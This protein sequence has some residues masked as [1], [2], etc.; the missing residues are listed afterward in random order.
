MTAPLKPK[1]AVS[2]PRTAQAKST[3]RAV[4]KIPKAAKVVKAVNA[5]KATEATKAAKVPR[6]P[7]PRMTLPDEIQAEGA[8]GSI[9]DQVIAF[10]REQ[11][12][13]AA[14]DLFFE[15]G[16]QRTTLEAVAKKLHFTKPF[17][18]YHFKDKE[19]VLVEIS[20]RSIDK[21]N[22]ALAA[23]IAAKGS[24][25]ERLHAVIRTIM[26]SVLEARRYTAIFFREQKNLSE[27]ARIPLYEQH[28]EFDAMLSRLLEEG[29]RKREFIVPDPALC[30][31][32]I[33]G[34]VGWAYNWYRP[35]G[36]LTVDEICDRMADMV[37]RQ[38]G[39][40]PPGTARKT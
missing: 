14:V 32:A 38:V 13:N 23:A 33:A 7:K 11:I 8:T 20:R 36:R 2:P 24:P 18:Y 22:E 4:A 5:V 26:R 30:A 15:N 37:L 9:R 6:T 35:G 3:R 34:M 19:A 17:I 16:Y 40:A 25:T 10:K 29:V 12:I 28:R 27:E 31:L 1:R 21:S 39:A